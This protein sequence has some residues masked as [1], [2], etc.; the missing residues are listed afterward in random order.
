MDKR[1]IAMN[2]FGEEGMWLEGRT[3][4]QTDSIMALFLFGF[5]CRRIYIVGLRQ[6]CREGELLKVL[7][8]LKK[9]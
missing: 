9:G 3:Q 5:A 2:R 7:C 1:C 4:R 8:G 6:G